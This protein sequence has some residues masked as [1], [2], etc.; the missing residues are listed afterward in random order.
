MLRNSVVWTFSAV[1]VIFAV[2]MYACIGGGT[3]DYS[4]TVQ[5]ADGMLAES[6]AILRTLIRGVEYNE[7]LIHD[8][9]VKFTTEGFVDRKWRSYWAEKD[10][11]N[12]S[13]QDGPQT[14]RALT[15]YIYKSKEHR[16]YFAWRI[17]DPTGNKTTSFVQESTFDGEKLTTLQREGDRVRAVISGRGMPPIMTGFRTAFGLDYRGNPWSEALQELMSQ[18]EVKGVNEDDWYVLEINDQTHNVIRLWIDPSKGFL[19]RRRIEYWPS[20]EVKEWQNMDEL[21]EYADGV[22]MPTKATRRF[23]SSTDRYGTHIVHTQSVATVRE[24]RV[25]TGLSEDDFTLH[26]PAGTVVYN[27]GLDRWYTVD[28]ESASDE[29]SSDD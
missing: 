12:A 24:L 25:N 29:K 23:Y 1:G 17:L 27:Q 5:A 28:D 3:T 20:G 4:S 26:L 9:A 18:I 2:S 7:S 10:S 8:L 16:R 6:Q 22:W 19:V 14:S 21:K 13:E 15:E 11:T